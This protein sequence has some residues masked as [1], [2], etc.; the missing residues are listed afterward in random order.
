MESRL[1]TGLKF[2][3]FQR[4]S[5]A[6]NSVKKDSAIRKKSLDY[7]TLS[8]KQLDSNRRRWTNLSQ[9]FKKTEQPTHFEERPS[10]EKVD[11]G[12]YLNQKKYSYVCQEF[13]DLAQYLERIDDR[14]K[15]PSTVLN[16]LE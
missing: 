7:L 6:T 10:S 2:Q 9:N 8:A 3:G 4:T 1:S 15:P 12:V 13:S 5:T 14:Y 16:R 11:L